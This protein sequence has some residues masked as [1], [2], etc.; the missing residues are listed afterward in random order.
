VSAV[1]LE[2]TPNTAPFQCAGCERAHPSDGPFV[3]L[4]GHNRFGDVWVCGHCQEIVLGANR[5]MSLRLY[6]KRV[7]E[8]KASVDTETA[9][10]QA[11]RSRLE[12]IERREGDAVRAAA[13]ALERAGRL[14]EEL[15][16]LRSTVADL[17]RSLSGANERAD[18]AERG[19]A[20]MRAL[21]KRYD[22]LE[23][24]V[25]E[26]AGPV[27]PGPKPVARKPVPAEAA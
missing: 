12:D 27:K 22:R 8:L 21:E 23:E 9:A 24:I 15:G 26:N 6:E 17:E 14:Q 11:E 16:T 2:A 4:P 5:L 3:R 1:E 25:A 18:A 7:S 19:S 13:D 20:V 10:L